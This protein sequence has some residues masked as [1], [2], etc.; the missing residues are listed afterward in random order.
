VAARFGQ[1]LLAPAYPR[2]SP[3]TGSLK[4]AIESFVEARSL[5]GAPAGAIP[6]ARNKYQEDVR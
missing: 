1:A 6:E 3:L 4:S 2:D 5:L